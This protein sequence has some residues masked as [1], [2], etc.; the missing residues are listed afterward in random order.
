MDKL[1][2]I[3]PW[4]SKMYG[5]V[6]D[7]MSCVTLPF[8]QKKKSLHLPSNRETPCRSSHVSCPFLDTFQLHNELFQVS[9]SE[10]Q[11]VL[12]ARLCRDFIQCSLFCLVFSFLTN[13]TACTVFWNKLPFSYFSSFHKTPKTSKMK[14]GK[15]S[16]VSKLWN[17]K[18]ELKGSLDIIFAPFHKWSKLK[19]G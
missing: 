1:V 13:P 9:E 18:I 14:Y 8:R 11:M 3:P 16:D 12:S 6:F 10:L 17:P 5:I 15:C 7:S 2:I 4:L 19:P